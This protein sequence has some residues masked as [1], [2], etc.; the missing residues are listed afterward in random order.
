MTEK[1]NKK[2][3]KALEDKNDTTLFEEAKKASGLAAPSATLA[4]QRQLLGHA[5][6]IY[7]VHW[8]V[9][10]SSS[11]VVSASQDGKLLVWDAIHGHKLYAIPLRSYWVM[12]TAY[13][14]SGKFVACGGLDNQCS[15]FPLGNELAPRAIRVLGE[16]TDYHSGYI[17]CCRFLDDSKILTA[18]GDSSCILWDIERG[19]K[20]MAFE[21]HSLDVMSVSVSAD[22]KTFV[23]GACDRTAKLWD[24]N[25]GKCVQTFV[26]HSL[27]INC[28]QYFPGGNAFA[29]ASDD[30]TCRLF[31]IRAFRELAKYESAASPSATTSCDFSISGRILYSGHEDGTIH[32]WD[33]LTG[34]HLQSLTGH[35][36]NNRRSAFKGIPEPQRLASLCAHNS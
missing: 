7:A 4:T 28:V 16:H 5:A 17:S 9:G 10:D 1:L 23:S 35:R 34:N 32:S 18:S 33:V 3:V 11:R 36:G 27:D 25:T 26:G 13:A 22:Q 31:D 6:K 30:A 14:P 12:A 8:G 19:E 29:S 2:L 24:M 20:I 21:E 15:I